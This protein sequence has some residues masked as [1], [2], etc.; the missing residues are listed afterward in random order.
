M[1][2]KKKPDADAPVEVVAPFVVDARPDG[3]SVVVNVDPLGVEDASALS[4]ALK[5]A[6]M[7]YVR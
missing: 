1:A 6:L 2:A 7:G 5:V 4:L 3:V